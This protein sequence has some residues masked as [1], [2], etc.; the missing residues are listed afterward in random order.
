S[1]RH[2][3]RSFRRHQNSHS[4]QWAEFRSQ[5]LLHASFARSVLRNQEVR[6]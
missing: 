5:A 6:A 1:W 3:G 2:S 4:F